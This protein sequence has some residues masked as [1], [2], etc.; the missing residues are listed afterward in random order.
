MEEARVRGGCSFF[1]HLQEIEDQSKFRPCTADKWK[2]LERLLSAGNLGWTDPRGLLAI[3]YGLDTCVRVF[4]QKF[5]DDQTYKKY[6][7]PFSP[8]NPRLKQICCLLT[9]RE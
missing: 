4:Y 8:P 1:E 5:G 9:L 6:E 2:T 7:K 3:C